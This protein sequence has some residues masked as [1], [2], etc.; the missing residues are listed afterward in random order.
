M[1]Q[2]LTANAGQKR[3]KAMGGD[4]DKAKDVWGTLKRLLSYWRQHA[5][6]FLLSLLFAVIAILGSLVGPYLLGYTIDHCIVDPISRGESI[7][8]AQL[9]WLLLVF[10]V[11]YVIS[12]FCT[13]FQEYSMM[14][15]TQKV[16]KQL[17][18]EM[19]RKLQNLSVHYFDSHMRGELMSYYTNDVELIKEAMGSSL[20]QLITSGM[21]LFGTTVIML[22]LSVPL[23]IAT[24]VTIPAVIFLSKFVMKRTRTYFAKQQSALAEL[25]SRVEESVG[26]MKVIQSFGQESRQIEL[27][28]ILNEE[29]KE[30]GMRAQIYSGIIMP[31]MRVLDNLSYILVT[32][33]GAFMVLRN[34]TT[35]GVIQSFLLYTKNFQKPI[36]TMATQL[37]TIQSAIAGAERIFQLLD[38]K[39]EIV[40]S[41]HATTLNHVRGVVEFQNVSFS[42]PGGKK[43][44]EDISFSVCPNQ[45]VAIVGTTGAGKTTLLNLLL[46]FYDNDSGSITIDGTDIHTV[47]QES[48]RKSM[49]IVLQDPYLFS[50]DIAYNIGYGKDAAT[51][52]E[53]IEAARSANIDTLID[54]LPCHYHQVVQE[55]GGGV[56]HGQQ[57]LMTIARA[58]VANAPILIL[59]EAT[60]NIDTRTEILIQQAMR[61]L[62][63]GKT[64]IVI[65][66]RLSTIKNADQ[67]L[68]IDKGRI[69]ECGRH[70]E[71]LQKKGTYHQIYYSQFE[72]E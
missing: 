2:G 32:L 59:D 49:S 44:L 31:L 5:T 70:E 19:T 27:F 17:R 12:S 29:V 63:V 39:P 21:T 26:G 61:R 20:V 46:R 58:F 13:W 57:Q 28:R 50:E 65:A 3:L 53:I 25:N 37:N 45:T 40:D 1:A 55:Q 51:E 10:A 54:K 11:I 42:Y 24:C 33:I 68:V 38:E 69:V 15:I 62:S 7:D 30:S 8:F 41:E 4:T 71:L 35:I 64:C 23:T 48:L 56:S 52:E 60:S 43:V 36:N 9:M 67:I 6:T 16:I 14:K 72:T 18:E 47:T 66:H 34:M 22:F